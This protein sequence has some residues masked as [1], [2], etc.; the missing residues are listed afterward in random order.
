MAALVS[1][2]R[3]SKS[4][5][6]GLFF[7]EPSSS[8][9]KAMRRGR[10]TKDDVVGCGSARRSLSFSFA[11][12]R[13]LRDILKVEMLQGKTSADISDLW[14]QHHEQKVGNNYRQVHG[15][16]TETGRSEEACVRVQR[17]PP[18]SIVA[19]M[20]NNRT[21]GAGLHLFIRA[22]FAYRYTH[23]PASSI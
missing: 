22:S 3:G 7:A 16:K 21:D 11:G 18:S 8:G 17:T 12:P 9:W 23:S 20:G 2:R 13:H 6:N 1:V 4:T 5:N 10:G 14:L 19:R 15:L